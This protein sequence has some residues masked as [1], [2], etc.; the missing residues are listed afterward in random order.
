M[1]NPGDQPPV[2]ILRCSEKDEAKV[3]YATAGPSQKLFVS[4][5]LVALPSAEQLRRF[6]AADRA[7]MAR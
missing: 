6:V 3:E 4:R 7:R 2:G 5:Y 1:M